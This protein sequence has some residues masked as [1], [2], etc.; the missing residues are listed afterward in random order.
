MPGVVDQRRQIEL[1][2]TG[3]R[4]RGRDKNPRQLKLEIGNFPI[5]S[6]QRNALANLYVHW[7]TFDSEPNMATNAKTVKRL[8]KEVHIKAQRDKLALMSPN[9]RKAAL[10]QVAARVKKQQEK[11]K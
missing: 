3:L 11:K 1:F 5:G 10:R 4:K 6:L 9:D 8:A 7:G 2:E